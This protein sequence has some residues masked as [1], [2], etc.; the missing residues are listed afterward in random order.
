[1]ELMRLGARGR[2]LEKA[3]RTLCRA[4]RSTIASRNEGLESATLSDEVSL[5]HSW[6]NAGKAGGRARFRDCSDCAASAA[7]AE[8]GDAALALQDFNTVYG[9][10]ISGALHGLELHDSR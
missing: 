7:N 8:G 1:V 5:P 6:C 9:V 10:R 2:T 4:S 3:A